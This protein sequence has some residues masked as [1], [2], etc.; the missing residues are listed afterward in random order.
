MEDEVFVTEQP[1][2]ATDQPVEPVVPAAPVVNVDPPDVHVEVVLPTAVPTPEPTASPEPTATPEPLRVSTVLA[3][4]GEPEQGSLKSIVLQV[5]GDYEPR[6]QTIETSQGDQQTIQTEIVPG[7][8]GV[9][10]PWLA[11]VLV[12]SIAFYGFFRILGVLIRG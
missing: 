6:T 9:D 4:P 11:G 7:V 8:A 2:V 5:F 3:D 1:P 10:W 12:F